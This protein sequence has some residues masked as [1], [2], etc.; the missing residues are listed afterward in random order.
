VLLPRL[1]T[2]CLSCPALHVLL[3]LRHRRLLLLLLLLLW[4]C[5]GLRPPSTV[6]G[7]RLPLLL[8]AC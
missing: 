3:H 1:Q 6:A 5:A 7:W 8:E 2:H 4:G